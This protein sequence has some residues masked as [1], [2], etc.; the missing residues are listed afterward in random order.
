MKPL[1][2]NDTVYLEWGTGGT[3]KS[4]PF[5]VKKAY[6]I[7]NQKSYCDFMLKNPQIRCLL[8]N[9][10]LTYYCIS[11]EKKTLRYGVPANKSLSHLYLSYV[12]V[13]DLIMEEHGVQH[14]DLVLVDG[15]FRVACALA[16]LKYISSSSRVLLDDAG[17]EHYE[18]IYYFYDVVA[19]LG[20][21]S[22]LRK[23]DD[24]DWK[25][26]HTTLSTFIVDYR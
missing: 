1:L 9:E 25:I 17:R 21:M 13:Q 24:I 26:W 2:T 15:R 10:R 20:D 3:T 5:Y 8:E 11:P 22:V 4:V 7:E 23:K 6:A 14:Y 18:A 12:Q 16:A 19:T